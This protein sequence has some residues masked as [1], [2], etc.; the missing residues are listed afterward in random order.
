MTPTA[1]ERDALFKSFGRAFFKRDVDALYECCSPDFT[2]MSLDQHGNTQAITG[3]QAVAEQLNRRS[4]SSG[5][6]PLRRRRL[7]PRSRRHFHDVP[8]HRDT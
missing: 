6:Y 7:S 3:R 5:K 8:P 1:T 2:W 4:D